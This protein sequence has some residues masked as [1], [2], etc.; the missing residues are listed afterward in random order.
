[1]RSEHH[2][3]NPSEIT[4]KPTRKELLNIIEELQGCFGDIAALQ[5]DD[6][7]PNRGADILRMTQKGFDLCCEARS[8]DPPQ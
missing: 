3:T 4:S 1:M 2:V 8:F 7:N 6:R 5:R